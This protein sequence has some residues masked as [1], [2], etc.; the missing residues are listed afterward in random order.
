M[1][2][3]KAVQGAE[4][5]RAGSETDGQDT[6]T[7]KRIIGDIGEEAACSMLV[8]EG[9]RIICRNF[10]CRTGEIDI[11]AFD[12]ESG[13]VVFA[14]VKTRNSAE[15]GLPCEFVGKEKQRRLRLTAEY[16][17]L[18]NPGLR[19]CPL[20]MDIVEILQ[21]DRGLFGRHIRNAF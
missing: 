20:R 5:I 10:S 21:T 18:R 15:Y 12:P 2:S 6:R 9:M 1:G 14:E 7:R 16:Y 4:R 19:R 3:S 11:V 17:L 13:A 8:S